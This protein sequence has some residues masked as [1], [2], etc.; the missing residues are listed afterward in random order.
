MATT[1]VITDVIDMSGNTGANSK[2]K[3]LQLKEQPQISAIFAQT[4]K[5]IGLKYI[6]TKQALQSGGTLKKKAYR[7]MLIS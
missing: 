5:L 7:M 4:Q 3:E 6:L 2:L 1:K